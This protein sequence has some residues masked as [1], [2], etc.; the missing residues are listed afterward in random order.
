MRHVFL[1]PSRR[2]RASQAD[3]AIHP[4]DVRFKRGSLTARWWH[5]GDP[6]ATAVYNALSATFPQGEALIV[7]SVRNFREGA[8]PQLRNEISA[9]CS[10]ET[11][12]SREH[13]AF[14]R[15]VTAAGYDIAPLEAQVKARLTMLRSKPPIVSLAATAAFEHFTSVVAHQI[16]AN[17]RHLAGADPEIAAMWRWHAVDEIEHKGVAYDTW[18]H[19]TRDWSRFKRWSVK[20]KVMLLLTKN[21]FP[22]RARGILELLRQDGLT[23][24]LVWLRLAWFTFGWP[25]V[26]RSMMQEWIHF[27]LPGYH[28][29]KVDDR[30]LIEK[31]E[32]APNC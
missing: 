19:A 21:Y 18:L 7:E 14:N 1:Y 29:W 25:G 13:L 12:H 31:V 17:P 24:P 15:R 23:G 10:Q 20:S 27:F 4:R 22:D 8:D 26:A 9:F 11:L 28:P 6:I 5:G 2:M 32:N 3:I 16:L 30:H